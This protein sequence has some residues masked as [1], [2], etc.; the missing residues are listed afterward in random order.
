MGIAFDRRATSKLLVDRADVHRERFAL[1]GQMREDVRMS[2]R[3]IVE[4]YQGF[5][6]W[7]GVGEIKAMAKFR[8][9]LTSLGL[10]SAP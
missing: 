5:R 1:I 8:E 3:E 4:Y 9:Y 6:Y 10:I 2:T 7:A